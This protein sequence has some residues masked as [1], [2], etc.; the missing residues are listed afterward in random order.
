MRT[1]GEDNSVQY[2][3]KHAAQKR[4]SMKARF[5]GIGVAGAAT[6]AAGVV[7]A[8]EAKA[9]GSIWDTVAQ[10]ETGQNWATNSVPGYSGGLGFANQYWAAFGGT[11]YSALPYQATRE[12]QIAVAQRIL[13]VNGP[14]AWPVCGPRAGL[15]KANGG[16]AAGVAPAATP[17]T[18]RSTTRTAPA[19]KAAPKATAKAAPKATTKAAPKAAASSNT[20]PAVSGNTVTV[21]LG[22]TLSALAV[23]YGVKGGWQALY[24]A[25]T[26]LVKNPNLIYVGQVLR[27]PA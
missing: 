5:A 4:R 21:K 13:A 1:S 10:C 8:S 18:S 16:A 12:Q 20:A 23:K 3:A 25:N 19:P 26:N 17:S 24:Q 9:A 22:D 27:I 2:F 11:Q 7:T 6:I 15:T 14:N